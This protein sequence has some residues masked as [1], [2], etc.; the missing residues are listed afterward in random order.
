MMPRQDPESPD[1]TEGIY[2]NLRT[3]HVPGPPS[4]YICPECG[5][6]LWELE[7]G[8]LLR[9]RCHVGHGYTADTLMS[10]QQEDLE[11]TLWAGL[12]ALEEQAALRRR[13]AQHAEKVGRVA[14]A[15]EFERLAKDAEIRAA[16]MRRLLLRQNSPRDLQPGDAP[17]AEAISTESVKS[18]GGSGV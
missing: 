9:F 8:A 10:D 17:A 2:D 7:D 16:S 4:P 11:H 18:G 14:N 15:R 3:G 12:R 13:M 5:G 6:A 1:V